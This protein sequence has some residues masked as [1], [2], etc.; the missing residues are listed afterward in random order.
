MIEAGC[1][2][3]VLLKTDLAAGHFSATDR[4][5]YF[6][7][8]AYEHGFILDS[9]GL[10]RAEASWKIRD[11]AAAAAVDIAAATV[12]NA[13]AAVDNAAADSAGDCGGC[14]PDGGGGGEKK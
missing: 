1:G 12:D 8:R 5:H 14:G 6:R 3:R 10:C 9:L 13:A 7:E 4:Y 11:E 2:S